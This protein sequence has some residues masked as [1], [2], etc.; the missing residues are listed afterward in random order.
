M[1]SSKTSSAG[2]Q[3]SLEKMLKSLASK[4]WFQPSPSPSNQCLLVFWFTSSPTSGVSRQSDDV[5]T[6]NSNV[7][8]ENI[9]E[10]GDLS[11]DVVWVIL[12]DNGKIRIFKCLDNF[13]YDNLKVK[14]L[15]SII[16]ALN[17]E[18]HNFI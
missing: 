5:N 2:S 3:N 10:N 13:F 11:G 9:P 7:I 1:T 6:E 4:S 18:I 16:F 12:D 8:F 15:I 14:I 17:W